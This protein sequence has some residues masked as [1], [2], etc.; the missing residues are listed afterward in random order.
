MMKNSVLP[1]G[2]AGKIIYWIATI[3]LALGMTATGILQ[4]SKT[5]AEGALA[6]PGVW[7]ISQLGYPVYFL[8]IIGV[9]KILGV[10]A[11]LVPK[12]PLVKE[13]A[14]AGFFFLLSGALFSHIA[15]GDPLAELVPSTLLL[16]MTLLSWYFRPPTRKI[17]SANKTDR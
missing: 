1:A 17:I 9:W 5:E 16:I 14:Y 15:V 3:W 4:L 2:K 7:G 13:W 10:I 6:P 12:F 11:I 8:T